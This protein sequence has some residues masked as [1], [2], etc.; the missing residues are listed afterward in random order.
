MKHDYSGPKEISP[1][2]E[3]LTLKL[4]LQYFGHLMRRTDSFEKTLMLGKIEGRRRGQQRMRWLDGITDSMDI[5][6]SKLREL[7]MDREAWRGAVHGVTNSWTWL[8]NWTELQWLQILIF[9]GAI[10]FL[11]HRYVGFS[12][13][14]SSWHICGSFLKRVLHMTNDQIMTLITN[15]WRSMILLDW[16]MCSNRKE[17]FVRHLVRKQGWLI[18]PLLHINWLFNTI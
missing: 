15:N 17:Y 11:V 18:Y 7:V 16:Q 1:E 10:H 5:S 2:L 3:G 6:L 4:K 13:I 14:H 9:K 8:S 12:P